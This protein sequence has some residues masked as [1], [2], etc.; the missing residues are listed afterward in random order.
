M[1]SEIYIIQTYYA[2]MLFTIIKI[3]VYKIQRL[4]EGRA[5]ILQWKD[6]TNCPERNKQ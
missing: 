3:N 5:E 4:K 6:P 2:A 1:W